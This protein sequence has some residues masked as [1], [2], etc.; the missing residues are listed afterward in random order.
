M[1]HCAAFAVCPIMVKEIKS[2][3]RQEYGTP[4]RNSGLQ[5]RPVQKETIQNKSKQVRREISHLPE[6]FTKKGIISNRV[7]AGNKSIAKKMKLRINSEDLD[8]RFYR[9]RFQVK[10]SYLVEFCNGE[11]QYRLVSAKESTVQFWFYIWAEPKQHNDKRIGCVM[12][13]R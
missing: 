7:K 9:D 13:R 6:Y 12:R 1:V 3:E 11:E 10:K 2:V 4:R 5:A 8:K